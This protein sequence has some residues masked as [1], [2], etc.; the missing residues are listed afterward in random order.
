VTLSSS[1]FSAV[2][3]P[4]VSV[5]RRS[6]AQKRMDGKIWYFGPKT[7]SEHTTKWAP[8]GPLKPSIPRPTRRVRAHIPIKQL[9]TVTTSVRG[10]FDGRSARG[11]Q[12]DR[13]QRVGH[14]FCTKRTIYHPSVFVSQKRLKIE[15]S[16]WKTARKRP[17]DRVTPTIDGGQPLAAWGGG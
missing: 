7:S 10:C 9:T 5:L 3:Q 15:M 17:V 11:V 6:L 13:L 12:R 4:S 16:G 14:T 8:L 2:S 1:R